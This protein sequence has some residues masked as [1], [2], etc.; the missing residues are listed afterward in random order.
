MK[1][2]MCLV[3]MLT[4]TTSMILGCSDSNPRGPQRVHDRENG[5]SIVPPDG[6][7]SR[8][9]ITGSLMTSYG[10]TEGDFTVNFSV[11]TARDRG[12]PVE[13][14]PAK[15]KVMLSRTLPG[16][17]AVEEGV[18]T[19]NGRKASY[20]SGTCQDGT[21]QIQKLQY[22]FRGTNRQIYAISFHAPVESFASHRATFEEVAKSVMT[23]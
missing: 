3:A 19:L 1:T 22:F 2:R 18:V 9:K 12:E 6:W 8:G 7:E 5:F 21:L 13:D 4:L 15:F 20:L 17:S 11:N 10:P 23:D 14:L 16:Y